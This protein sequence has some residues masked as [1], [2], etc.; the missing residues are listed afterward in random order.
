[1]RSLHES[2]RE[3]LQRSAA[4][5]LLYVNGDLENTSG[6][7]GESAGLIRE[8]KPVRQISTIRLRGFWREIDRLAALRPQAGER[9]AAG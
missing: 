6:S 4:R 1:M 3:R 8:I 5:H 7:A 2:G 9:R